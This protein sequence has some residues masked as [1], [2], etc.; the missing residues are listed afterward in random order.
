MNWGFARDNLAVLKTPA[1]ELL[2]REAAQSSNRD[3]QAVDV[4]SLI[5]GL[6][7]VTARTEIAKILA[8]E[9]A[10]IF[11][12]PVEEVQLNRSLS[13]IGMDSLMGMELRSAAQ[14][15]LDIEIPMG[16]IADG[17]TI[18]DIAGSVVQRIRKGADKGLSFTEETLIHQHV[19]G[20]DDVEGMKSKLS[21]LRQ[22][23]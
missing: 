18:E 23:V 6:D 22:A 8:Q 7:D 10:A 2:A 1:Y 13:D 3:Q 4:A 17:T 12:M 11:R 9:V 19:G 16:A 14:Q 21:D 20:D 5:D 15:K